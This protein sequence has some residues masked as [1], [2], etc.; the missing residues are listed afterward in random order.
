MLLILFTCVSVA[1]SAQSRD[2]QKILLTETT[3]FNPRDLSRTGTYHF[4]L[5]QLNFDNADRVRFVEQHFEKKRMFEFKSD[6]KLL[7]F[8]IPEEYM[9]PEKYSAEKVLK[10]LQNIQ[11][12]MCEALSSRE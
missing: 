9:R 10:E 3:E 12:A 11:K 1:L 6:E 8:Q 4:D 7:I 2:V 5:S